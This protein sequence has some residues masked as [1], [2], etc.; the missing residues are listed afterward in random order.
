MS[1]TS[2]WRSRLYAIS[3]LALLGALV[4]PAAATAATETFH[5]FEVNATA[6]YVVTEDC[7]DGTTAQTRVTVI[8]GHEEE[9]ESGETTLDSDFVTVLIRG[10]DCDGNFISDRGSGPAEFTFSPS[11]QEASVSG[12]ITTSGGRT[13]TVDM[14]WEGTGE[15]E[16][17]NNVTTFPGFTGHF[18]G[19]QRDAVATG[20]VVVDGETLVDGSTTNAEIETLE[21]TNTTTG[22]A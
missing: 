3:F 6:N 13:V 18:Q 15:I 8:G 17:T 22:Q 9:S 16:T 14:T 1:T 2:S 4:V 20:T 21:D 12:T 10:F 7:G 5:R 11:L 19:K